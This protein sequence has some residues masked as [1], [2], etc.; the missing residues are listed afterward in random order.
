[1][2]SIDARLNKVM[3]GLSAKERAILALGA[4]KSKEAEDPKWR[5][6][7]P[8][9]Q[10]A[11]FGRY[12]DL[13]NAVALKVAATVIVISKEVEKLELNRNLHSVLRLWEFNLAEI[14]FAASLVSR[15]P[16]SESEHRRLVERTAAGYVRVDLLATVLA[17]ERRAWSDED[18]EEVTWAGERVVKH[19]AWNRLRGEADAEIR[20]AAAAGELVSKGK[21]KD[22]RVRSGSFDTWLG[23]EPVAYPTWAGGF[24]V[25]PDDDPRVEADQRN[26]E[27]LQKALTQTPLARMVEGELPA[28][29]DSVSDLAELLEESMKR[30]VVQAWQE[31]RAVEVVL[32]EAA[33]EFDGEDP[34]RPRLRQDLD[35]ARE[36]LQKLRAYL[37]HRDESYELAEPGE[38]ELDAA[39]RLIEAT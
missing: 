35:Q 16:I 36:T 33:A 28:D 39:R 14:D 32:D 22:L 13:I 18:L 5:L 31:L 23:R 8:P 2:T 37:W 24:E 30:A 27:H 3:P 29:E 4:F 25:R 1:M 9:A 17:E 7:M 20:R 38:E 19:E 11:E 15:E 26:L 21:G 12:I 34:L 6:T 10:L